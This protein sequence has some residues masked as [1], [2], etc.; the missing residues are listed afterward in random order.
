MDNDDR[1]T[2]IILL[3]F[4]SPFVY[5]VVLEVYTVNTTQYECGYDDGY[6]HCNLSDYN[7]L[8]EYYR[9]A[10]ILTIGIWNDDAYQYS[11]GYI[12]GVND[13][14]YDVSKIEKENKHNHILNMT[15]G[16]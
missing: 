12:S 14:I 15:C 1:M 7:I 11:D 10:S 3:M 4:L 13:Y 2:I 16:E 9:D 6:N 8:M 5:M